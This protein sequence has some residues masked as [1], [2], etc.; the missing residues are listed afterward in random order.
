MYTILLVLELN[1]RVPI[2]V[3]CL[4]ATGRGD[5]ESSLAKA[6]VSARG[7]SEFG[8]GEERSRRLILF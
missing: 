1:V 5:G 3:T 2:A 8:Y 6:H 4:S 7:G